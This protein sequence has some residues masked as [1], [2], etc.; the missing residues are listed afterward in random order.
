MPTVENIKEK[1][2]K[3]HD[4][5][6]TRKDSPDKDKF[7]VQHRAIWAECTKKLKARR[8]TLALKDKAEITNDELD[9]LSALKRE[10]H[11]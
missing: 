7:D 10:F 5:L 9:E 1:Y 2:L 6:G 3:Q 8:D 11:I 4:A